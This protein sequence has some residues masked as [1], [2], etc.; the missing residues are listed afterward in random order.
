MS[1]HPLQTTA[2]LRQ[3]YERYLKTIYPFQDAQ[4]RRR[5]WDALAEP[6]RLVK[7]P[8][9]E[10]SPPYRP[11]AALADLVAEGVIAA[12]F[13]KLCEENE[14]LP[15]RRPLYAHQERAARRAAA[16]HNLIVATGTG[17]GKTEAFLIP[18]LDA[19]LRERADGTLAAPG[20]RALL[21]YP[22]NALANDQMDRLRRLLGRFPDL[23]FGRYTGETK[24]TRDEALE[25]FMQRPQPT[26]HDPQPPPPNELLARDEIQTAPPHLLLTNYAMLEYLLL[27]PRDTTLFDGPT[28]GHSNG[29]SLVRKIIERSR[30]DL[31]APFDGERTLADVV[32]VTKLGAFWRRWSISASITAPPS[33][34]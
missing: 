33:Y 22:M 32:M 17:S 30:P 26:G 7:G 1:L 25:T 18:I 11:G 27:R 20:V 5:F 3:G 10:A 21:L 14:A 28:G 6:D 31:N 24:Y 12:D 34:P 9:L 23:T 4:L 2:L 8:L 13:A 29:Y 15:Y 19:L 16:G